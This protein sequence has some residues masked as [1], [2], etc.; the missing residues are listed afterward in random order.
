MNKLEASGRGKRIRKQVNYGGLS[1]F[2]YEAQLEL[3]TQEIT[4]KL[5]VSLDLE[6][7]CLDEKNGNDEK[8]YIDVD[9][10]DFENS[11]SESQI[12]WSEQNETT[13]RK[14][15][16][17]VKPQSYP[18]GQQLMKELKHSNAE[19]FEEFVEKFTDK[20]GK[21]GKDGCPAASGLLA[22]AVHY[23]CMVKDC[24]YSAFKNFGS[25]PKFGHF[26]GF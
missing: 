24:T 10:S 18:I 14:M 9:D 8:S 17:S 6:G 21:C 26:E 25:A 4:G 20:G 23:H 13:K 5:N 11:A 12:E 15:K 22:Y 3:Q 2:E 7:L 16:K 1:K 19:L